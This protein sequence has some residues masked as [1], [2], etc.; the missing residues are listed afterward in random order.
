MRR[1]PACAT[2]VFSIAT[3]CWLA[4]ASPAL[5]QVQPTYLYGLSTFSGPLRLEGARLHVDPERNETYV[6]Y[7]N[8]VRVFNPSGMEIFS[9]GD[10]LDLGQISDAAVDR[11][12]DIILL[13]F[14]DSRSLVTRCNFRGVPV[15]PIEIKNLPAGMAFTASRMIHRDGLFYFASLGTASV[16]VT[17]ANGDFRKHIEFLEMLDGEDRKKSSGAEMIGITADQDGNLFF[18]VPTLFKVFKFAP[19]GKLT[20]FGR[21]GSSPGRFGVIA[22]IAT[23]SRGNLL[24]TDK[25]KCVVMVFDKDFNFLTEFGYRGLRP[26]NLIVPDDVAI[27]GRDRLYV[28]QGRRR[29]ISVF[30]LARN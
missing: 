20:S 6:I 30:A 18:T 23:D 21:S 8:I 2:A 19:D 12:G 4:V 1:R 26:E 22:G 25:L 16:I 10:D 3:A 24:V 27:D 11:N 5:A 29:G 28:S 9:F 15:G 14:K 7:Q 17:D 13:S